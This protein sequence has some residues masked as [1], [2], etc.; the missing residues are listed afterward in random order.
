MTSLDRW[1][2]QPGGLYLAVSQFDKANP[3]HRD[4]AI[5]VMRSSV[6]KVAQVHGAAFSEKR[7]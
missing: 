3:E 6:Q 4:A 2:K 1:E 7:F 5:N